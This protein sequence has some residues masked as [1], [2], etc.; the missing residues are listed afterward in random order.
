MGQRVLATEEHCPAYHSAVLVNTIDGQAIRP[1]PLS[2]PILFSC[3]DLRHA[4][5]NPRG[6]QRA[7]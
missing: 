5:F 4:H 3:L 6:D 2:S 7:G 1:A